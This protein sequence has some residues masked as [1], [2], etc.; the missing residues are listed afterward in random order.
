VTGNEQDLL[1][2]LQAAQKEATVY[3][4]AAARQ[5]A[6][7]VAHQALLQA[8]R[9]Q[10]KAAATW[11]AQATAGEAAAARAAELQL[12]LERFTQVVQG[13]QASSI[14]YQA[15]LGAERSAA[16]AHLARLQQ[17]HVAAQAQAEGRAA[18]LEAELQQLSGRIH[19][20]ESASAVLSATVERLARERDELMA[21]VS[22]LEQHA[23]A[24]PAAAAVSQ[25]AEQ[26]AAALRAQV[27]TLGSEA[28]QLRTQLADQARELNVAR[29][30]AVHM[31][32]TLAQALKENAQL[33]E[34]VLSLRAARNAQPGLSQDM[35]VTEP[36]PSHEVSRL[37]L[38]ALLQV[39][40]AT[41]ARLQRQPAGSSGLSGGGSPP[42]AAAAAIRE[43]GAQ[44]M[45]LDALTRRLEA[46]VR[47]VLLSALEAQQGARAAHNRAAQ[48]ELALTSAPMAAAPLSPP[49]TAAIAAPSSRASPPAAGMT[50]TR[51][52]G[53]TVSSPTAPPSINA[54]D[55][56]MQFVRLGQR[57]KELQREMLVM[58]AESAE[59][60]RRLAEQASANTQLAIQLAGI[61]T[62]L[63]SPP[64]NRAASTGGSF[65]HMYRMASP[66]TWA[67][68][69]R[70]PF[71]P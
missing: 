1:A 44:S 66:D 62:Q 56:Q 5:E 17:Q 45:P 25:E 9:Q 49:R 16:G 4:Q 21:Q 14:T 34:Q 8:E 30:Q 10:L 28:A 35:L 19:Q 41:Q 40:T 31:E 70:R 24:A 3:K 46:R 38:A 2:K 63:S 37:R 18:A 7:S 22:A 20:H 54:A 51:T 58:Q 50:G 32:R 6:S 11:Q 71:V 64:G 67:E 15:L 61:T 60:R 52:V 57:T 55:Q 27:S 29:L 12:Q 48:L 36:G 59:L 23:Q 69:R 42:G 33:G 43:D 65:A 26:Q 13:A 47:E 53:L 39:V 68:P